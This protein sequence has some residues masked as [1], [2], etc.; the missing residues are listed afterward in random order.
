METR[1]PE[2]VATGVLRIAV[3]GT[4]KAVPT[5][6]LKQIP[7]WTLALDA[8]TPSRSDRPLGEGFTIA[9]ETA[10][11]ALLDL[12]LAYDR[13]GALGGREWLEE[14]ADP[15]ELRAAIEAMLGNVY[16][17]EMASLAW[18]V[19][20]QTITAAVGASF[21]PNS[22]KPVSTS[23]TSTRKRSARRSTRSS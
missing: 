20:N 16:P 10:T 14:H 21:L 4:V 18:M 7:E 19:L 3:G 13:T 5:L 11:T 15:A 1:S 12:I 22:T 6:K 2:D 9:L 8:C 17:K 23:G